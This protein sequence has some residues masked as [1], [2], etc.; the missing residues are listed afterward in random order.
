MS[1]KPTIVNDASLEI[2]RQFIRIKSSL[3]CKNFFE[4]RL[5]QSK[6][7]MEV[8]AYLSVQTLSRFFKLTESN[9][10][11]AKATLNILSQYV[12][13]NSFEE[14][15]LLNKS[16]QAGSNSTIYHLIAALFDHIDSSHSPEKYLLQVI[17]NIH[18]VIGRDK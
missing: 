5:L 14:F 10:H 16:L 3:L 15:L 11:S 17:N 7:L 12:G 9:F 4:M 2:L 1:R 8:D 6:I 18:H 13:Y